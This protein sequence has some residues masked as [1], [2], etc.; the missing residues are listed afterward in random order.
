MRN[1]PRSCE[2]YEADDEKSD[3]IDNEVHPQDP[4]KSDPSPKKR[5]V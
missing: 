3:S 5:D 1:D 2:A 4:H